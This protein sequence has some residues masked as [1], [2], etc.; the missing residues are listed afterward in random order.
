MY[1]YKISPDAD[2]GNASI[3]S[4]VEAITRARQEGCD[5]FSMSFGGRSTYSDGSG[6]VCQAIDVATAAGMACFL[7]AGN[8]GAA[9]QHTSIEIP[10]SEATAEFG[11]TVDNTEREVE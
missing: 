5:I 7:S 11:L 3:A 1:F 10:P 6:S 8:D 2:Q 9:D 4:I